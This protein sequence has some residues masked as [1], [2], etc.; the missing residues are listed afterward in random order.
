MRRTQTATVPADRE[1]LD[2]LFLEGRSGILWAR[3]VIASELADMANMPEAAIVWTVPAV[4]DGLGVGN[5]LFTHESWERLLSQ[6]SRFPG[7]TSFWRQNTRHD[8]SDT[9]LMAS[10]PDLVGDSIFHL[11]SIRRGW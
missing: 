5:S 6:A 2:R 8:V 7:I 10:V 1:Y 4:E 3:E 9:F 11:R